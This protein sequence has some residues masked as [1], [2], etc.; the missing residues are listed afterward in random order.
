[1]SLVYVAADPHWGHKNVRNFP[2]RD[3]WAEGMTMHQH[4]ERLVYNWNSVVTKRDTVYL[5]GDVGMDKPMGYVT[6]GIIPRLLGMIHVVGG[7]HDTAEILQ[8]FYRVHGAVTK[9][10]GNKKVVMTHI[11]IHPQEMRWDLNIHGHLHG[12]VVRK[13]ATVYQHANAGEADPR[14]A[15]VSMEHINYT[16]KLLSQVVEEAI[17]R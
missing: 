9:T 5:L 14:Y 17:A 6:A 7:N 2:P 10:V 4:D 13:G 16:P 12:N 11:P 8:P 15:C 3:E 1:M